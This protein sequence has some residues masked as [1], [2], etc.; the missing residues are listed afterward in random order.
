MG[1]RKIV[2]HYADHR[3]EEVIALCGEKIII[4]GKENKIVLYPQ[5]DMEAHVVSLMT[6]A[7]GSTKFGRPIHIE[8]KACS[9]CLDKKAIWDLSRTEL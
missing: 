3:T 8:Y 7:R 2:V 1:V 5:E 9:I 6:Y 4:G